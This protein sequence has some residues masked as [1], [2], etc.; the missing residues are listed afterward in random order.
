MVLRYSGARWVVGLKTDCLFIVLFRYQVMHTL[1][2]GSPNHLEL[3]VAE[4]LDT[5]NRDADPKI[6]RKAHQCLTSYWRKGKWNIMWLSVLSPVNHLTSWRPNG[7]WE[8]GTSCD[9]QSCQPRDFFTVP[10][11][12][13]KV[14]HHVNLSLVNHVTSLP[15]YLRKGKWNIMWLSVLSTTWLLYSPIGARESGTSCDPQSC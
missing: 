7:P 5:F 3:R 13:G 15:S 4:A 10:L 8:S 11:V 14:E 2:D 6:R 12:Q 9:S 1:C